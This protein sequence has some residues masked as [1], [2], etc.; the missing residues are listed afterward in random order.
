[1]DDIT[2]TIMQGG[3]IELGVKRETLRYAVSRQMFCP[4]SDDLLDVRS[5]VLIDGSDHGHKM[6]IMTA[7]VYDQIVENGI[8]EKWNRDEYEVLDGRE[9]F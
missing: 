3:D 6:H 5:A 9:L 2:R 1:M 7:T 8:W 4:Y